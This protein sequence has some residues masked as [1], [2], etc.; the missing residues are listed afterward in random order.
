MSSQPPA[1][2]TAFFPERDI[3]PNG[4][5]HDNGQF[6][7]PGKLRGLPR[8]R[9]PAMI[10]LAVAMAGA[11]V[12]VSA[13]V[14][15]KADHQVAVVMVTRQVPAGAVLTAGDLSTTNVT[16]GTGIHV[17]PASQLG[18]V[19]GDVAAAGLQPGTL[20]APSDLTTT[21]PPGPGQELVPAS[22]KPT[23][24][25]ASGLAPGD[26]VLIVATPGDQGQSGSS[27][28]SS[29]LTAPVPG[30]VEAVNVVPDSDGLDV[31][32]LLV[33][34]ASGAAVAEQVSTGQFALIVTK[35]GS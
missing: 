9:R 10:A 30:V 12:L 27:V 19:A 29:A 16:V 13:A 7:A 17:I 23:M 32:D 2:G 4:T 20:L 26:H 35:R 21:Q 22:V 34:D 31:V 1:V 15:Q 28:G 6:P 5:G 8:R 11:G 14:Y 33:S 24:L 25:P 18:Q 3:A